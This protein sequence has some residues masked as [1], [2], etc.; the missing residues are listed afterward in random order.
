MWNIAKQVVAV[1]IA[2]LMSYVILTGIF[3][4]PS[5]VA[6]FLVIGLGIL[7]LIIGI[8]SNLK[9]GSSVRIGT[10]NRAEFYGV[11]VAIIGYM[12]Y[13]NTRIDQI[14]LELMKK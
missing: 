1:A 3:A 5:R 11:I 4:T 6:V 7:L 14:M 9:K 8:L 2:V 12:I 10:I 13:M